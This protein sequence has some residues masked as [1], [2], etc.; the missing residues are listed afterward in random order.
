MSLDEFKLIQLCE[1]HPAI[2]DSNSVL[3]RDKQ[4]KLG[5]WKEIAFQ[6]DCTGRF[7]YR[8]IHRIHSL[9]FFLFI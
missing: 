1:S 4:R 7:I 3:F 6:L 8:V 5:A 9:D 2:W